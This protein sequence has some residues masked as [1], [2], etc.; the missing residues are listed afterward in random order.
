MSLNAL[1]LK[2]RHRMN[3]APY[4]PHIVYAEIFF[5][6]DDELDEFYRLR[7]Y[8]IDLEGS[9]S[10]AANRLAIKFAR[11]RGSYGKDKKP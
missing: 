11:R 2:A 8:E 5:L 10:D 6:T 7:R 1:M 3:N 9:A 4:S